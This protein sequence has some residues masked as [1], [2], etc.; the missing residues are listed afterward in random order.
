MG[1]PI[2]LLVLILLF[3]IGGMWGFVSALGGPSGLVAVITAPGSNILQHVA[4][5]AI[6][7]TLAAVLVYVYYTY[8]LAKEAWTPSAAF[9][10]QRYPDEPYHFALILSNH[11][12]L[13]LHCWCRLNAKVYGQLV[14]LGGFYDAEHSFD[15]QPFGAAMG[16]F[17]IADLLAKANRTIEAMRQETP[18]SGMKDRL[19]LNIDFWYTPVGSKKETRNPRQPHYFDFNRD[20]MVADF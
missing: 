15:V 10:L 18:T 7:L 1:I 11:S 8:L 6:V 4:N 13:S 17:K 19:Y 20:V 2:W 12:K 14:S 5:L 3:V 16:H 9:A